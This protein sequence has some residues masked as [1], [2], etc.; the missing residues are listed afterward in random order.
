MGKEPHPKGRRGASLKSKR[1]VWVFLGAGL[2]AAKTLVYEGWKSLDFLGFSRPK[3]AFST[4]YAG[5]SLNEISRALLPPGGQRRMGAGIRGA[6]KCR[7]FHG[8]CLAQF[9]VFSN[10]IPLKFSRSAAPPTAEFRMRCVNSF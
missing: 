9:L 5:F 4:G 8:T 1:A 6:Q 2:L 3:L 10:I 7:I